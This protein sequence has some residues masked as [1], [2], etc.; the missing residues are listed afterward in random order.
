M[1]GA[2]GIE[3]AN[4]VAGIA[5]MTRG[6]PATATAAELRERNENGKRLRSGAQRL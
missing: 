2:G 5:S 3:A 1:V 6:T 4:G